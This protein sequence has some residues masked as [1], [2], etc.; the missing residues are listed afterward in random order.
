MTL[1]VNG[2]DRAVVVETHHT[3]LEVL[4]MKLGLL[5]AREACG[6]GVCGA[7]TVLIDG[8]PM[9][10]CLSLAV[11]AEGKEVLTVEGLA[12]DGELHPVQQA[13]VDATAF[14]CSYCTPG[15]ILSAVALLEENP[16]P[17]PSD[18]AGY[19]AGN[20]CRCG[21]YRKIE[22]AVRLAAARRQPGAPPPGPAAESGQVR[23]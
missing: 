20:L 23:P 14:Q 11:L 18:I 10:S 8:R 12:D 9:S 19:L 2:T 16:S 5:G 17:S 15:F 1:R 13:F 21:S 4:R 7:C 6:I 22:E 3:L